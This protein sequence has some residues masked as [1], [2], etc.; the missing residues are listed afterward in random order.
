MLESQNP[1]EPRRDREREGAEARRLSVTED[2]SEPE[3]C[4][5]KEPGVDTL[6]KYTTLI[7]DI[8]ILKKFCFVFII[9]LIVL[10]CKLYIY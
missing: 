2:K 10:L 7:F 4:R 3:C 9:Q 1:E 5:I 8:L 6:I